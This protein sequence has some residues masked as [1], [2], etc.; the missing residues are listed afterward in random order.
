MASASKKRGAHSTRKITA[1]LS[2]DRMYK[3]TEARRSNPAIF[4]TTSTFAPFLH[5][6]HSTL[7][8]K[9]REP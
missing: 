1:P 3:I 2:S 5:S 7:S 4:Q 6:P 9:S 8:E